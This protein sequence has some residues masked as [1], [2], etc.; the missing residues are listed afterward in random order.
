MA[1]NAARPSTSTPIGPNQYDRGDESLL[2][3][4]V[5]AQGR[6][7]EA[8]PLLVESHKA[9]EAKTSAHSRASRESAARLAHWREA[10]NGAR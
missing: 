8:E 4:C 3:A 2:G 9:I 5:A 7:A 1:T 6:F 10:R